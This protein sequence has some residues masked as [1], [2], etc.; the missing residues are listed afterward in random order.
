MISIAR[1]E[2]EWRCYAVWSGSSPAQAA[3]EQEV[4]ALRA[5]VETTMPAMPM[6][7]DFRELAKNCE[8]LSGKVVQFLDKSTGLLSAKGPLETRYGESITMQA[9]CNS[10][11]MV[12]L[13]F[14]P[15]SPPASSSQ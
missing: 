15:P 14:P 1:F 8:Y 12:T 4:S 5:S 7:G 2:Y 10:F 11:F 13:P 3:S 9:Y 6:Q